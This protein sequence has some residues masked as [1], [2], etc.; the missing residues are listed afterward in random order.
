MNHYVEMLLQP[1]RH[2]FRAKDIS[3]NIWHQGDLIT[4][5]LN[6]ETSLFLIERE[7]I[8]AKIRDSK[9]KEFDVDPHTIGECVWDSAYISR[10]SDKKVY[11]FTGDIVK[12]RSIV[13]DH[14]NHSF[15]VA[16][17]DYAKKMGLYCLDPT[18]LVSEGFYSISLCRNL[19]K[20]L[21]GN[22]FDN[23]ELLKGSKDND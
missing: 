2:T 8:K 1:C 16:W 10:N 5:A 22:A 14:N 17:D 12:A 18:D 7:E 20:L 23:P 4:N 19:D 3:K 11:L 15:L 9:G 21:I 13:D 6:S